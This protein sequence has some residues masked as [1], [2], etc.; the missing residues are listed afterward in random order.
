M[1]VENAPIERMG[2]IEIASEVFI[3]P[4]NVKDSI[5]K[6][7]N[8]ALDKLAEYYKKTRNTK[9]T[10]K[11]ASNTTAAPLCRRVAAISRRVLN[12]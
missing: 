7:H 11:K 8:Y 5:T 12:L 3:E 2:E 9:V 6:E 4:L 10:F 1:D